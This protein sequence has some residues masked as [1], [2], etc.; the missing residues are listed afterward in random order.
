MSKVRARRGA[1]RMQSRQEELALRLRRRKGKKKKK[2]K[3]GR[4]INGKFSEFFV[5]APSLL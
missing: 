3:Q 1:K 2:R 5:F 4:E